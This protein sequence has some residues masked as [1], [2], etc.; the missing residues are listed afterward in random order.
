MQRRRNRRHPSPRLARWGRQLWSGSYEPGPVR[1][2]DVAKESSGTQRLAIPC[3]VQITVAFVLT[4]IVE[5]AA[6]LKHAPEAAP[7]V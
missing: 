1:G 4:S 7:P 3:V 2:M 5:P 6:H